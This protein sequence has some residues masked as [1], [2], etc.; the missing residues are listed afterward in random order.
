MNNIEMLK[1]EIMNNVKDM[2]CITA[3]LSKATQVLHYHST[4]NTSPF[5]SKHFFDKMIDEQ[6]NYRNRLFRETMT[7]ALT[8][9][10]KE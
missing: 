2:E 10:C 4:T 3:V 1:L 9:D 8:F 7:V 5:I 6:I